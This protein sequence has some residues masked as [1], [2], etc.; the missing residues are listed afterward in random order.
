MTAPFAASAP[1]F[2]E[3]AKAIAAIDTLDAFLRDIKARFPEANAAV[4]PP[5][6]LPAA[7]VPQPS[8]RLVTGSAG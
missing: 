6:P 5:A 8:E 4:P 3:I 2:A 1:E 7:G